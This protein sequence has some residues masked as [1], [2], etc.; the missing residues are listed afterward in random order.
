MLVL[1]TNTYNGGPTLVRYSALVQLYYYSMH[2]HIPTSQS[3]RWVGYV[4]IY[5]WLDVCVTPMY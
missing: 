1:Y 2:T 5:V 3:V 4:H